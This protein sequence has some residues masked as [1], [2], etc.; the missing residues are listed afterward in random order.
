MV[1]VP[2]RRLWVWQLDG[3]LPECVGL[4]Y[5]G[6]V[7]RMGESMWRR[8]VGE[9]GCWWYWYRGGLRSNVVGLEMPWGSC[10]RCMRGGGCQCIQEA[11]LLV[12]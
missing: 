5:V 11:F 7:C 1:P 9:A 2:W 10:R 8:I 6:C 4:V 12:R 3:G